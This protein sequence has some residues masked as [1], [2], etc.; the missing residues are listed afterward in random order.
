[1]SFS[2]SSLEAASKYC[3]L[4]RSGDFALTSGP[5]RRPV[6]T[7]GRLPSFNKISYNVRRK[8]YVPYFSDLWTLL[9]FI[10][11]G[12]IISLIDVFIL[13]NAVRDYFAIRYVKSTQKVFKKM[14]KWK[15]QVHL[16]GN[17]KWVSCHWKIRICNPYLW[18]K[19]GGWVDNGGSYEWGF[20]PMYSMTQK[21]YNSVGRP[22]W[23]GWT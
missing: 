10:F 20:W 23:A 1:M 16:G 6:S 14:K 8:K 17:L 12:N 15:P 11:Y 22:T 5:R 3:T 4:P 19:D 2:V 13:E 9:N 21:I 7:T 18:I